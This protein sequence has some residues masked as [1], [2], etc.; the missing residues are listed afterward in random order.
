MLI[1]I[2]PSGYSNEI[3]PE[4]NIFIKEQV[5]ALSNQGNT[6]VVLN[7]KFIPLRVR[8]GN[9][10]CRIKRE[11]NVFSVE[12]CKW[13]K[14]WG[15]N[16][17]PW[18]Y[19]YNCERQMKHLYDAAEAEFGK[20]DVIYAHFSYYAG[21]VASKIA[22]EKNIPLVVQEHYSTLMQSH[23]PSYLVKIVTRTIQQANSF[24]CVSENLKKSIQRH[25]ECLDRKQYVVPNLIDEM[26]KY[27]E[28]PQN[29]TFIFFTVGNF[30]PRKR[31]AF[32]VR[33]FCKA[34]SKEDNVILRIGGSGPEFSQ[35]AELISANQRKHQ[36]FLLGQLSREKVVKENISSNC[37]VLASECETFG[38][39]YREA[40]SIGRPI[41]TTDH[42][43]FDKNLDERDGIMIPVD[44]EEALVY[45]LQRM[46]NNYNKYSGKDI[47]RRCLQETS[48]GV[49]AERVNNILKATVTNY[50]IKD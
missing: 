34:F 22:K 47:S 19:L 35:I 43:G 1:F 29:D 12:Y 5:K 10:S 49:I 32:L 6:I 26:F 16:K 14:M 38:V 8:Q 4:K 36:I 48:P 46:R 13:I 50:Y 23:I 30:L 9:L 17:I 24:I 33:C 42:G 44:D 41:I 11:E 45:A 20:P 37:F 27:Y 2:V 25:C 7:L 15:I 40:M 28:V 18:L 3:N 39:V 31:F 21:Y